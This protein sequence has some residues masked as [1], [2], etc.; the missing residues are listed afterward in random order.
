MVLNLT[1]YQYVI[2]FY[3]QKGLKFMKKRIR[4]LVLTLALVMLLGTFSSFLVSA[5]EPIDYPRSPTRYMNGYA[6][7]GYCTLNTGVA[8]SATYCEN[9]AYSKRLQFS[10]RALH[11]N[12]IE[13]KDYSADTGYVVNGFDTVSDASY[14][15]AVW[16]M[17]GVCGHHYVK[18]SA[19]M[20]WSSHDCG[21][22]THIG[23]LS[24]D[25]PE[26]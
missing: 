8:F 14:G 26:V 5:E 24:Y 6:M 13:K 11:S 20:Y 23:Q 12:G 17:I 19:H 7:Y 18:A 15:S 9:I 3:N 25:P 2:V 22:S 1:K 21:E 4:I 10:S 16:T